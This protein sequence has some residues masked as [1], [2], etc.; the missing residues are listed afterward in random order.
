MDADF[1][2]HPTHAARLSHVPDFAERFAVGLVRLCDSELLEI[3]LAAV[4]AR[5][6]ACDSFCAFLGY[7]GQLN[8][9]S[10]C[11]A[12]LA[13]QASDFQISRLGFPHVPPT[14]ASHQ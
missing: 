11:G 9:R 14:L 6:S 7:L 5:V 13:K 12:R 1:L 2:K 4:L 3:V 8:F 10:A